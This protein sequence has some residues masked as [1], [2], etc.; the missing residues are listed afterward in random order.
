MNVTFSSELIVSPCA[1]NENLYYLLLHRRS[2]LRIDIEDWQ[3]VKRSAEY[4]DFRIASEADKYNL[5]SLGKYNGTA[6]R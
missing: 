4:D 2:V 3:G 5:A 1:G 6:G